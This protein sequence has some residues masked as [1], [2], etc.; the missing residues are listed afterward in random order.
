MFEPPGSP[1][2][3]TSLISGFVPSLALAERIFQP[4]SVVAQVTESPVHVAY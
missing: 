4:L 1:P 3:T 2:R